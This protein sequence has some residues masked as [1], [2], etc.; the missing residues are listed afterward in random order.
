MLTMNIDAQAEAGFELDP[1]EVKRVKQ[2]SRRD[3]DSWVYAESR[4]TLGAGNF[5]VGKAAEIMSTWENLRQV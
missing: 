3:F 2:Q 1:D 4:K 5:T